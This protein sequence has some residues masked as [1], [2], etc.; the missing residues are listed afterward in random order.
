MIYFLLTLVS[1]RCFNRGK[2]FKDWLLTRQIYYNLNIPKKCATPHNDFQIYNTMI[3]LGLTVLK[4]S[5]FGN[6]TEEK[7]MTVELFIKF[8]HFLFSPAGD[9]HPFA[10][11]ICVSVSSSVID[12]SDCS[13]IICKYLK[14]WVK[15][16]EKE[17]YRRRA[18]RGK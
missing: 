16:K 9:N 2:H 17:K 13:T 12:S 5:G 15:E 10:S 4:Y 1:D 8:D 6:V 14:E 7:K 11:Y 18:K 3:F